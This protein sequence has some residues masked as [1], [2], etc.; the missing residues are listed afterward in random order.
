MFD[1]TEAGAVVPTSPREAGVLDVKTGTEANVV[2]S[3]QR[4][5]VVIVLVIRLVSTI[6]EVVP[7]WTMVVVTG[8][9]VIVV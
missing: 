1:G 8:Q 2:F 3:V 5:Q 9:L 7:L 6:I 4:G